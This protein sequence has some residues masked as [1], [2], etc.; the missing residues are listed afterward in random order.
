MKFSAR[1]CARVDE[2]MALC[3]R[4]EASLTASNATRRSF[5]DAV[6]VHTL[7]PAGDPA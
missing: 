6:L 1:R 7:A 5:L 4:P 2:L 3:D